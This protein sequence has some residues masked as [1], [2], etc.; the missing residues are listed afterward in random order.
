MAA[1]WK[2]P[3]DGGE[4]V[5]LLRT[6]GPVFVPWDLYDGGLVYLEDRTDGTQILRAFEF[7]RERVDDL[8]SLDKR[9]RQSLSVSRDGRSVIFDQQDAYGS[10]LV[11]V[12]GFR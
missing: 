4:S 3:L 1:F 10:D 5:E 9:A 12:E 8:A 2:W 11:L 6:A 7:G